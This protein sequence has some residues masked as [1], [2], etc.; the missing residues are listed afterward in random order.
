MP[1]PAVQ[2]AAFSSPRCSGWSG[3]W[4]H[5]TRGLLEE[6]RCPQTGDRDPSCSLRQGERGRS[7]HH[8]GLDFDAVLQEIVDGACSL[9]NARYG[10]VGVFDSSGRVR[11]FITSGITP[12]ERSLLGDPTQGL[13]LLGYLNE[14]QEPLRLADL[15]QHSRSVGF[16]ENL[17]PMKSC[18]GVPIRREPEG[19]PRVGQEFHT[20][21]LFGRAS[22]RCMT[23]ENR[24]RHRGSPDFSHEMLGRPNRC[25]PAVLPG[26]HWNPAR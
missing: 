7:P 2:S 16:P 14:I 4:Q 22:G 9:T 15:S 1:A 19:S 5:E 12:E 10:A 23:H 3:G 8:R 6:V 18:L 24:G 20:G 17:P 21:V 11:K 26:P 25:C 13:G